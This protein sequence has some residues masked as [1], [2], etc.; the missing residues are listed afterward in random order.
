MPVVGVAVN[1][2]DGDELDDLELREVALPPRLVAKGGSGVV[3]VHGDVHERVENAGDPLD[4]DVHVQAPPNEQESSSMVIDVQEDQSFLQTR[5]RKS[6]QN[7][8]VKQSW[9][10][11]GSGA[12][13]LLQNQQDSIQK[14]INLGE[15]EDVDPVE[16]RTAVGL[17]VLLVAEEGLPG[18][19]VALKINNGA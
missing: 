2:V 1:Q 4:G 6:A 3:V 14:L 16:E 9:T 15:I 19:G 17:D 8:S 7:G 12:T 11:L 5:E 13:Y 10:Q 18:K